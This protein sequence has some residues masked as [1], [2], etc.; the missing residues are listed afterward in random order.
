MKTIPVLQYMLLFVKNLHR[1]TRPNLSV[2]VGVNYCDAFKVC[3]RSASCCVVAIRGLLGVV[4]VG[5]ARV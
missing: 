4:Y 3:V 5:G 1:F 2:P